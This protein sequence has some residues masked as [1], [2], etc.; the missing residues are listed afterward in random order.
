MNNGETGVDCGGPCPPCEIPEVT[1]FSA[2]FDGTISYFSLLEASYDGTFYLHGQNDSIKIWLR[3]DNIENPAEGEHPWPLLDLGEP[4]VEYNGTNYTEFAPN[5]V[6]LVTENANNK[7]TGYFH[8]NLL[9]G[10]DTLKVG[11]GNFSNVN[12]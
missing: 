2:V 3:F 6:V 1:T 4:I 11:G 12:Y 5:S 8:L 7:I 10:G 9:L